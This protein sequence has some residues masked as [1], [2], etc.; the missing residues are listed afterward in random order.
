MVAYPTLFSNNVG[1]K[2]AKPF[3]CELFIFV[4]FLLIYYGYYSLQIIQNTRKRKKKNIFSY[5]GNI[6]GK[7]YL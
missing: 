7:Y 1:V 3:F 2:N 6:L 4:I 5:L